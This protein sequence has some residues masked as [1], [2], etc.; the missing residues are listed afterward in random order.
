MFKKMT[1][2]LAVAG[3][4]LMALVAPATASVG[5]QASPHCQNDTG[6]HTIVGTVGSIK[7][8]STGDPVGTVYLCRTGTLYFAFALYEQPMAA[9]QW[10][11]VWLQRFD[12]GSW[13]GEVNCDTEPGGNGNIRPGQ[14]RCWTPNLNGA[15]V[16]YTF[17]ALSEK[18]T[19]GNNLIANGATARQR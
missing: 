17:R 6:Y 15:A 13:V 16:R 5:V 11:Q 1:G 7:T 19:T 8:L 10:A 3:A 2:V 18:Y 12:N 9:N 4:A 14:R